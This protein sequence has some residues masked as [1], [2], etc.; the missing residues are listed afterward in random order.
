MR[1]NEDSPQQRYPLHV[2]VFYLSSLF[3]HLGLLSSH[4]ARC[5]F[6]LFLKL[7]SSSFLG[8]YFWKAA[9]TAATTT[10]FGTQAWNNFGWLEI[11]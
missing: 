6:V 7:T 1:N 9:L 11:V 5:N 10:K 3:W 8:V 2:K 4:T